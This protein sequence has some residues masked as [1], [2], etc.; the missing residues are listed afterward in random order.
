MN[1]IAIAILALAGM[2]VV[3]IP[4]LIEIRKI[5]TAIT[6]IV[7]HIQ[8]AEDRASADNNYPLI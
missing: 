2:L 4:L 6:S 8:D 3:Y 5:A 1:A 7:K